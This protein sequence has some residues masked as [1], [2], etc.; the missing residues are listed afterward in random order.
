MGA[1]VYVPPGGELGASKIA[2][3]EIV[4]CIEMGKKIHFRAECCQKYV[5][6]QKFPHIKVV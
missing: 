6:C 1:Y 3:F 5:L 2:I 4:Y